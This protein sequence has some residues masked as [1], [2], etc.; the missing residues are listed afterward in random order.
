RWRADLAGIVGILLAVLWL[1][2]ELRRAFHPQN[3]AASH[4]AMAEGWTIL[5]ALVAAA[6]LGAAL[7]NR[8]LL[9]EAAG[10]MPD[11]NLLP[12]K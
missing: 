1:V 4:V 11:P 12:P 2:L 6:A 10:A 9:A 5:L 8:R 3:M 7:Y